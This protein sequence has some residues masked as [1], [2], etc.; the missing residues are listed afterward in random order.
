MTVRHPCEYCGT[1]LDENECVESDVPAVN[2]PT[3]H[4]ASGCRERVHALLRGADLTIR[5]LQDKVVE[6]SD[7]LRG[8][9]QSLRKADQ[10]SLVD[11]IDALKL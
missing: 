4:S 3:R 10:W 6:M 11:R 9:Y 8:A 7:I 5:D 2:G 1:M